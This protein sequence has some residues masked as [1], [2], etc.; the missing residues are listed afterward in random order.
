M[1]IKDLL[2]DSN[3]EYRTTGECKL[4]DEEY[5]YL[6]DKYGDEKQKSDIGVEL[7]KDKVEL[8]VKMGSLNKVKT[9]KEIISWKDTKKIPVESLIIITPKYDGLSLL[10][11][12]NNGKF[13]NAYTRGNGIEGQDVTGHFAHNSLGN[14]QL[15]D[16]FSGYVYGEAIMRNSVFEDKYSKKYKNPRNMV[17]G[18]LNR[19]KTVEETKDISFMA[20]GIKDDSPSRRHQ[21]EYL[22]KE[23]NVPLNSLK[24][25]VT[26]CKIEELGDILNNPDTMNLIPSDYQCD[27]LVV[28]VSLISL[29]EKM[30][31]ETNSLNPAYGRAWKPQSVNQKITTVKGVRWQV[32]K[33]GYLKPVVE[34]EPVDIS[35][36]TISN[37]TGNNAKYIL[38]NN[39][40]SGTVVTIIR[41]GDVIPK[42][43]RVVPLETDTDPLPSKCPCC[44]RTSLAWNKTNT[45]IICCNSSCSERV[46]SSMVHFFDTLEIEAIR[47]G[48]IKQLYLNGNDNVADV[49]SM[50]AKDFMMLDG[51]QSSKAYNCFNAIRE[52][53]IVDLEKL[54]HACNLFEGLG[55]RKLKLLREY[56][57]ADK[58]PDRNTILAIGGFSDRSA[59]VYLNNI[60]AFWELAEKLPF[61]IKEFSVSTGGALEGKSFVFTGFRNKELQEKIELHGGKISG[62]VS[63]KTA[64]L[65]CAN[66]GS[67]STKEAKALEVG[68]TI[69]DMSE[70]VTMVA[71]L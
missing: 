29:Q 34:I 4:T 42:I 65:V 46:I 23:I 38:E 36:V 14:I 27:G 1:S 52:K 20:F 55:S 51:F 53:L 21:L 59:D 22:N 49:C 45:E 8:P 2:S 58:I 57:S 56:N 11:E 12:F 70:C 69:L 54:Q 31:K 68:A 10:V 19:K 15:S 37:V 25:D 64:Y 18:L 9:L 35:G 39:I 13:V 7:S 40:Q 33:V 61:K 71:V 63:K 47:E 60:N 67:G 62:G 26:V 3:E 16:N 28:E 48:T 24:V 5:D 66:K 17:A 43:V 44:D 50:T 32:S 6:L 30:G 41:S